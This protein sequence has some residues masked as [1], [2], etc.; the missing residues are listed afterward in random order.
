LAGVAP[1]IVKK[2]L[3]A[4]GKVLTDDFRNWW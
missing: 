4:S 2:V 1:E 3:I